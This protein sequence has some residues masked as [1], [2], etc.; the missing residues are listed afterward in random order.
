M[1]KNYFKHA[2]LAMGIVAVAG[3]A[4]AEWQNVNGQYMAN[5]S[6]VPGWN[7][8]LTGV[9]D[10]VGECYNGAFEVYQVIN[11]AP[12]GKYTLTCNA[13]YRYSNNDESIANMKDGKNHNAFI[14][15]GDSKQTV[16][17]LFDK[18]QVKH[19]GDF[20]VETM[21]PNG[22]DNAAVSF[23]AGKYVNTVSVEHKGGDL[24]F[25]IANTGGRQ[26]E[27]TAFTNF[28]LTGPNG[29]VAIANADFA[30]GLDVTKDWNNENI[31]N[32]AKKPD[33]NKT[34]GVYRKT[35]A[36]PYNFA[37]VVDL[38][39][40]KYRFG[41]QSFLRYGGSGNVSGKQRSCKGNANYGWVEGDS[42]LDLWNKKAEDETHNAYVY[43]TNAYLE[44][45]GVPY[46]PK[47]AT[48][49]SKVVPGSF[50][51]ETAI[52]NMFAETLDTYPDNVFDPE[53]LPNADG[54]DNTDS[55]HEYQAAKVFIN[56]P[57]LYRNYVE[58][59]LTEPAK[60]WVGIKKDVNAP[61]FYWNPF[62]DYTLEKYVAEGGSAVTEVEVADE[63]APVEYYNLQGVRVANPT[64]GLYIVKQGKKV[65]KQIFK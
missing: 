34:G 18:G 29:D 64:N 50:Y 44:N 56:N 60:V 21:A 37:T 52:M 43:A 23:A 20:N 47:D 6:Y 54:Y 40:G 8:A 65:T 61:A 11:D 38:P 58:F 9:A 42:P 33:F 53:A 16:E 28:K 17:G 32:E 30:Q 22:L 25:G 10:K 45:A 14:F 27:W 49:A 36:S 48:T 5:A 26:D 57:K 12:A 13:F 7:G 46:K 63:N 31:K 1:K 19:E 39:A 51:N 4:N 62:R 35:N 15:I 41:V 3:T 24:K 2:A 59:E 55:G